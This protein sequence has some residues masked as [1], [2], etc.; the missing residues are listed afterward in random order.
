MKDPIASPPEVI[1]WEP[2]IIWKRI[3]QYLKYKKQQFKHFLIRSLG[4]IPCRRVSGFY[5]HAKYEL[6]IINKDYCEMQNRIDRDVLDVVAVFSAQGHS[7][8]SA[9][10]ALDNIK[11]LLNYDVLTP[12]TGEDLEWSGPDLYF[13]PD[14]DS[15]QK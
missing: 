13:D 6:A 5:S 14:S 7:G 10:Y 1:F 2:I 11:R 9:A 3:I 15:Y 8:F 12:L 4:G